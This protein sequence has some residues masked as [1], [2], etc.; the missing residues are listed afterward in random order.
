MKKIINFLLLG[1]LLMA[2][3]KDEAVILKVATYEGG[4]SE[5][6]KNV[7]KAYGEENPDI[8]VELEIIDNTQYDNTMKIRN[9]ANQLPD[10]FPTRVTTMMDYK[11]VLIPLDDLKA[12]KE[13]PYAHLFKMDG[14]TFGVPMYAFREFVYY[15]KSAFEEL[16]LSVPTTWSEFLQLIAEINGSGKYIPIALGAKDS[17]TVYPYNEFMPFIVEGGDNVLEKMAADEAPFSPGKPFY[18]AYKKI[19]EFYSMK[20]SGNDPLGYGWT[21]SKD[22]FTAKKAVMIAAGQWFYEEGIESMD[23]QLKE[24]IGAFLLPVRDSAEDPF[25][26]LLM[27]ELFLSIPKSSKNQEEA[28]SFINY[29]FD[30]AE[31]FKGAGTLIS[32]EGIVYEYQLFSD[33]MASAGDIEDVLNH[34]GDERYKKIASRLQ[35]DV[36]AMGQEML[37]GQ[38][39]DEYMSSYNNRWQ[40]ALSEID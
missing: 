37:M 31:R 8:Q 25:R 12:G 22:M 14:H 4:G 29:V 2:C 1:L 39:F 30:N 6:L 16:G 7:V 13:N 32:P 18:E 19:D 24:D 36:K 40:K 27:A 34:G 28:K 23:P 15:R 11:N 21:Q 20:P 35:F 33:A 38:D 17:W 3:G 5:F 9:T 10:V 26:A